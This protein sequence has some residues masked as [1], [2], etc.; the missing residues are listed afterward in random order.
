MS[1]F[2]FL[3]D[4]SM[5]T[6]IVP[7]HDIQIIN[8]G[9]Q[10]GSFIGKDKLPTLKSDVGVELMALLYDNCSLFYFDLPDIFGSGKENLEKS[11]GH[12]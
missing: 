2:N 12:S 1:V 3:L 4:E 10:L 7:L 5:I 8:T 11:I 6:T 9:F